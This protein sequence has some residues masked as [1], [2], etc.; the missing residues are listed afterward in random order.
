MFLQNF[1]VDL[2]PNY[3]AYN[4]EENIFTVSVMRISKGGDEKKVKSL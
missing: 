4:P 1:G 3:I 2:S